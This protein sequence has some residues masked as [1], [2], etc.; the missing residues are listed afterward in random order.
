MRI[1]AAVLDGDEGFRRIGRQLR[2]VNCRATG[3]A[4]IGDERAVGGEDGDIR[5]PFRHGELVDRRQL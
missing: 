4:A 1:E 5:R 3:I 2:E